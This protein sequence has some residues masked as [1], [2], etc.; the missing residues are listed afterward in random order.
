MSVD[1][2]LFTTEFKRSDKFTLPFATNP[3]EKVM[4]YPSANS[5]VIMGL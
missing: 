4:Y 5:T 1:Y 3:I 2:S